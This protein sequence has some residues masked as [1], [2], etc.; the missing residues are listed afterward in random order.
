M[1][2]QKEQGPAR[3]L[4]VRFMS[5]MSGAQPVPQIPPSESAPRVL[6]PATP[7]L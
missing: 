2:G 6:E 4:L 7:H 3:Q 5:T 1:R